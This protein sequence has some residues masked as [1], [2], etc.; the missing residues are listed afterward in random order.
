[1]EPIT[2]TVKTFCELSGL[3]KT[4]VHEMIA[5]GTLEA[6]KVGARRLIVIASYQRYL[7]EQQLRRQT[8][9]KLQAAQS[10]PGGT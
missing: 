2:A 8:W 6:V 4:K 9:V 7:E 5:D 3:G 10:Q 1:M